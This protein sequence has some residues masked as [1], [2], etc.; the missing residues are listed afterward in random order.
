MRVPSPEQLTA[1]IARR[2]GVSAE[3]VGNVLVGHGVS[4]LPVPPAQRSLDIRRVSF[5]GTRVNT[6]WDGPFERTFEFGNGVTALITNENLRGKSTVLE[7]ITWALR[8]S[9][10]R[11]R[12]DVKPWFERVELEYSV[13][14]TPMAVVLTK[15]NS[16]FI[17]DILRADSVEVLRSY[18]A[19]VAPA[20]EVHVLASGLSEAEFG[21][22]QDRLMLALLALEPLTN[23]QMYKG[24]DQGRPLENTWPAYFGGLYLPRAGSEILLGDTV[25][26][27]IPARILQMF[28]NVPLMSTYIRLTTLTKQVKQDESNRG[29]RLA[30]DAAARSDER[31]ALVAELAA[32][33]DELATLPSAGR[34][35]DVVAAELREAELALSVGESENRTTGITFDEAKAARQA[36]ERQ[37][38]NDRETELAALLFHGLMPKH[39]PRC[40][41][42]IGSQRTDL[43]V[44]DHQCAVC[45][46]EIPIASSESADDAGD[47]GA[48]EDA[49]DGL[50]ALR[51]AE[52][53][54]RQ[55]AENAAEA[56]R[57][58][59]A[60]VEA[61]TVELSSASRSAEFQRRMTLQL[62]EARL[63]G[64]LESFPEGGPELNASESLVVLQAS[65]EELAKVTGAAAA[66][67]FADLNAEIVELGKKFGIDNLEK[68][69]LNRRGGMKVTTAG[70][71]SPFN[72]V[73]G[74]ERL[75][76]RVAV[77]VAL[78][79]VGHRVGVGSH[80]GLILLDSPGSDELT[81][82]DE[83]TLLCELDSLKNELSGLQVVIASAEPAAVLG[84]LPEDSIYASLDGSPLW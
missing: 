42:I 10:R 11:L 46:K 25:F 2:A 32:V 14:G 36:E 17:A 38:N 82:E 59:R 66:E 12:N 18:L 65:I 78:L 84:N 56:V 60:Q 7:L 8:G 30:E 53:A 47:D 1:A 54:A 29:R 68:V 9:P 52:E 69:E 73:T 6:Q 61:L 4:L 77:V 50:E 83:A 49:G 81:V 5:K 51:R 71:E 3:A 67:V 35:F 15:E 48:V 76:L 62:E 45:T 74:G 31:A 16:E 79:R 13:N 26:A 64:R 41:Q 57:L 20:S 24:S 80:P 43:E 55:T 39:C 75:R 21:A 28:C 40:E 33:E 72:G 22:Q 44:S 34:S 63:K 23:F 27:A 37:A 58:V 70:V 19:G